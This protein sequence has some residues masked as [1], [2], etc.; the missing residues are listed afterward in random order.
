VGKD[1]DQYSR[2]TVQMFYKDAASAAY[3][4]DSSKV[5]A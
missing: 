2:E 1:L 3:R 4:I 5:P